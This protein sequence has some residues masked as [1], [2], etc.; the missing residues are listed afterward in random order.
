MATRTEDSAILGQGPSF[1]VAPSL[2]GG[3]RT[4]SGAE[5]VRQSI[6]LI[7]ATAP[8]ERLMRPDFGCAVHDLVFW[9]N[10]AALRG[11]AVEKVREALLAWEPRIDIIDIR[12]SSDPGSANLL[13]INIDYRLRYNNAFHNIVYPFY[14]SEAEI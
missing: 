5:K 2:Q 8:G 9:P 6:Y 13:H 10:S 4:V 3:L 1:P 12:A 7:L 11:L 14:L